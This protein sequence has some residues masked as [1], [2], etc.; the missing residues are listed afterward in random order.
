MCHF[1][2]FD[3]QFVNF[4]IYLPLK[5]IHNMRTR[6]HQMGS[7]FGI[8]ILA[9]LTMN[10]IQAAEKESP[11]P[12][13]TTSTPSP[14]TLRSN[15][16]WGA[17][18]TPNLG[19]DFAITPELSLG[20]N[21]GINPWT[22]SNN[23][24]WKH[25]LLAPE[26]RHWTKGTFNAPSTYWGFNAIYSHYNVGNIKMPFGLYTE[27]RDQRLQGDMAAIGAFY[28]YTWRINRLFRM[29]I[30]GGLGVG[31]AWYD[32]Y[33]CE[34]CGAKIGSNKRPFLVPKLS[35][36]MV[37]NPEKQIMEEEPAIP[38]PI[39]T[40]KPKP[41]PVFEVAP[42]MPQTTADVLMADNPVLRSYADYQPYDR[43]RVMRRDSGAL[44][45]HFPLDKYELRR[46]FRVNAET[47]DRIVDIT[48]K[49][50]ADPRCD[51]R[52][53]QIIGFASI[54]GRQKHNEELA[55]HRAESLKQY[56]QH[57]VNTPDSMYEVNNGGEAWAEF[58]D[59]LQEA[60][61]E[62]ADSTAA[63]KAGLQKAVDIIDSEK[64]LDR[65]EQ[66]LRRLN[67][68]RTWNYIRQHILADQRNSGY[69]RVYFDRAPDREAEAI[70]KASDLIQQKK[71]E[72]ALLILNKVSNDARSWNAIGVCLYMTGHQQEALTYFRKAAQTGNA[73][74]KE[75]LR[76]MTQ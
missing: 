1:H 9:L 56:I 63:H 73:D 42:V 47:L 22:F 6:T 3:C 32:I 12:G 65:R 11:L 72:E 53:I 52:L 24:K 57:E 46:D 35:L 76:Q 44:Y 4:S 13:K 64:N 39:D 67:G 28:G 7:L 25:L 15:L 18:L 36:N 30:E 48:R 34:H 41:L 23:K 29:E 75:N 45:V 60:L 31:Y 20:M 33:N 58:R 70:N 21:M 59:Q 69:L 26:L 54:E 71:Y 43:T 68:G 10:T 14:W 49:I 8:I 74:A 66:Q 55:L 51:V 2:M 19:F 62:K 61:H 50:A 16:V 37:L 40:I 17:T 27:V 5:N 38:Q